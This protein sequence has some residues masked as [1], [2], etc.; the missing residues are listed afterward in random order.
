MISRDSNHAQD[1]FILSRI[2]L[3]VPR[4]KL[5]AKTRLH[6]V[7][8]EDVGMTVSSYRNRFDIRNTTYYN[9]HHIIKKLRNYQQSSKLL[10]D[11]ILITAI[12]IQFFDCNLHAA[13]TLAHGSVPARL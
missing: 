11:H 9:T 5:C 12:L 13:S 8:G 7:R 3:S 6:Y 4:Y 1:P 10:Q 2:A